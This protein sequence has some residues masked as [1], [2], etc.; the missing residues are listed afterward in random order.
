MIFFE[1]EN[2]V[3]VFIDNQTGDVFLTTHRVDRDNT[4]S[5]AFRGVVKYTNIS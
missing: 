3:S 4:G 1:R 2:I 5:F